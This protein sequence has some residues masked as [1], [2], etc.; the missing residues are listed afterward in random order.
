MK[1]ISFGAEIRR[2]WPV[3]KAITRVHS[4][5]V[6]LRTP[7]TLEDTCCSPIANSV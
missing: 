3:A 2:S 6:A 7:A 4:G 1:P 5:V